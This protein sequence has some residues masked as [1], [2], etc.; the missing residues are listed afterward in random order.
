M[1]EFMLKFDENG[2]GKIEMSEVNS[3]PFHLCCAVCL[4]QS[5]KALKEDR[6]AGP[7][8]EINGAPGRH[9]DRTVRRD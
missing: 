9:T 7:P 3:H 5:F 2:D 8:S 1:K 6:S 4:Q